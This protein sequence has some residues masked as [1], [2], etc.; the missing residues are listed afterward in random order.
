MV[1]RH[2]W[3]QH[4]GLEGLHV[5]CCH[6]GAGVGVVDEDAGLRAHFF[7]AGDPPA[8]L[9]EL[10]EDLARVRREVVG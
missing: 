6:C 5:W 4:E 1:C 10:V 8:E 7:G 3:H 2:H 9:V